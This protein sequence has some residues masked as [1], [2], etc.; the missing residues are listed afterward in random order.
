MGIEVQRRTTRIANREDPN[1]LQAVGPCVPCT[2][3]GLH[4]YPSG[5]GSWAVPWRSRSVAQEPQ[6]WLG[7]QRRC[8]RRGNKPRQLLRRNVLANSVSSGLEFSFQV[9]CD[10]ADQADVSTGM[11]IRS[12]LERS[13][14]I[15]HR[16]RNSILQICGLC[17]F[18]S[19]PEPGNPGCSRAGSFDAGSVFG[20]GFW[21][22]AITEAR[23]NALIRFSG[24]S[25]AR[26]MLRERLQGVAGTERQSPL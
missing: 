1:A 21:L 9:R 6:R 19:W 23:G 10:R 4:S 20:A 22:P 17:R 24:F 7:Y 15:G 16:G 14:T 26:I 3:A 25:L 2:W 11:L 8:S 18:L 12:D 13:L 5:P